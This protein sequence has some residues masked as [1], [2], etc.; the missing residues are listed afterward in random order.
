MTTR[1]T[2]L[3]VSLA[4]FAPLMAIAQSGDIPR[5]ENGYP[6]F[7]RF[8]TYR[9]PTPMQRPRALADKSAL[10]V[11]VAKEWQASENVRLNRDSIVNSVGGSGYPPGVMAEW[12]RSESMGFR[13]D[14]SPK[15]KPGSSLSHTEGP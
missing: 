10:T 4:G 3:L 13:G 5:P 11:V 15:M 12:R 2:T 1:L 6:D 8:Y 7:Q 9:T 14:G